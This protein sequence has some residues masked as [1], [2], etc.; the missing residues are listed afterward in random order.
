MQKPKEPFSTLC[1][2]DPWFNNMLFHYN[3]GSSDPDDCLLLVS[4][5]F[6]FI[7]TENFYLGLLY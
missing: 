1:H 5:L 2:L 7:S 3:D 4:T 6:S